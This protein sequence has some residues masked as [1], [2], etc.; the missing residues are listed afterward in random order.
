M[1][2]VPYHR[3]QSLAVLR[4]HCFQTRFTLQFAKY[5]S[6]CLQWR[7]VKPSQNG[8]SPAISPFS[9]FDWTRTIEFDLT[10]VTYM[11]KKFEH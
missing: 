2:G 10:L 5:I 3:G 8:D 1:L 9:H 11:F 4:N 6:K 7:K